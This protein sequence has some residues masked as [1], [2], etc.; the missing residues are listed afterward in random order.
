LDKL[1]KKKMKTQIIAE[2]GLNYAYGKDSLLF[3]NNIKRLIDVAV[4]AGCD[5]VKFQK[6]N[7]D[8]CVPEKEKNKPKSV[9]WRKEETTYLQYKK[10]IELWEKEYDEVDDYCREKGIAW[11]ASVWDKESVDF[12]RRYHS[13]LPNGKH[14]V[15][16]KIPSAL[17]TDLNLLTYA[18]ECC[19]EV[20]ISTGMSNQAEIDLA[21]MTAHPGVVFHTNSTYP[22]PTHELK[23][24]Y[25]TYL[26][27]IASEFDRPFEIGYSGH[28]FGL[29]TTIAASVIGATWIERHITLDRTLWGSDQMAS[30]EPQGLIKLVKSIR[31]IESSRGGYEARKVLPSEMEKRKTLRGK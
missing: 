31:D 22:A 8:T 17:I 11:F 27:H 18:N 13:R 15:M 3:M 28:E 21:I 14:G 10:D 7:P 1:E 6:R 2:I 12:M 16:V 19:D 23:L 5:Y 26:K 20:V 29:T 25:L 4:I 24:D 9:P 30:V